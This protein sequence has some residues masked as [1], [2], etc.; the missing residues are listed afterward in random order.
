MVLA[1]AVCLLPGPAAAAGS[2][3]TGGS[4]TTGGSGM[5]G[6]SGMTG[7]SN[8]AAAAVR[9][10][11]NLADALRTLQDQGLRLVFSSEIVTPDMRVLQKPKARTPRAQ[12]DELLQPHGLTA[13]EG[14]GRI[15][16]IVRARPPEQPQPRRTPATS[17]RAPAG[18]RPARSR[19]PSA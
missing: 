11:P 16:Q 18:A 5:T 3:F 2:G 15:V 6:D 4:G 8:Q 9:S 19:T 10:T 14:P 17:P 13:E 1:A 7:G 12:L